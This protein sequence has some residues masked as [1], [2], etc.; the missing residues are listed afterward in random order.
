MVD[1]DRAFFSVVSS[2]WENQPRELTIG[3]DRVGE[4][5]GNEGV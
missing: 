1:G 4:D 2:W 3:K 5:M